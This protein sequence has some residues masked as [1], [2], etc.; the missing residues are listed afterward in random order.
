VTADQPGAPQAEGAD[1][2]DTGRPHPARIDD[3][4]KAQHGAGQQAQRCPVGR[5]VTTSAPDTPSVGLVA[6]LLVPLADPVAVRVVAAERAPGTRWW[7]VRWVDAFCGE[8]LVWCGERRRVREL[9]VNEA[10]WT[11]A[12]R[13]GCPDLVD[14][15]RL[16]GNLLLAGLTADGRPCDVPD[17]VVD[18]ARRAGLLAPPAHLRAR[19]SPPARRGQAARGDGMTAPHV[20]GPRRPAP[21]ERSINS[22]LAARPDPGLSGR[23]DPG[24]L[25]R[26]VPGRRPGPEPSGRPAGVDP[27]VLRRMLAGFRRLA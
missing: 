11:L 13:L 23:P 18:A 16:N 6:A 1:G 2:F 14:Q 15:I 7:P 26:R 27:D 8:G 12:A 25:A 21:G 20:P 19:T 22:L 24:V 10:A 9:P 17:L 3:P 4:H 5:P